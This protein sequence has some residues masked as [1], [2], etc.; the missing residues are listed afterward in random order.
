MIYILQFYKEK[1]RIRIHNQN[2]IKKKTIFD[3]QRLLFLLL[4]T[5]YLGYL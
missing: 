5:M 4:S 3:L 2:E 1:E